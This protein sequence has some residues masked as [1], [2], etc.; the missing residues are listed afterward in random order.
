MPPW[1]KTVPSCFQN[2]IVFFLLLAFLFCSASEKKSFAIKLI[3]G[4]LARSIYFIYICVAEIK[5]KERKEARAKKWDNYSDHSM[6]LLLFIASLLRSSLNSC[7]FIPAT[8]L[9]AYDG[10]NASRVKYQPCQKAFFWVYGHHV[11]FRNLPNIFSGKE[12][13]QFLYYN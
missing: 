10:S 9:N 11:F 4:W 8:Y 1:H 5:K 6:V 2:F 3:T 7:S 12:D 13:A